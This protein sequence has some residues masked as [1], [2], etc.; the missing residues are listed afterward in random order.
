[1]PYDIIP[2]MAYPTILHRWFE[3]VWS[4]G[5][6]S[7]VDELLAPDGIIHRLDESGT[8]ARGPEQFKPF[9]RRML[10]AFPDM[11]VTV[12]DYIEQGDKIAARWSVRMT[13]HGEGLGIL[14]TGRTVN[15]TGMSFG[16]V[17]KGQLQEGWNNWDVHS[18]L[19]QIGSLPKT[20]NP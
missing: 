3:E 6:E 4:Q 14:P 13:H 7:V 1:M 12:E 5:N 19:E 18:M 9:L 20:P 2:A 8:E 16:R 11:R 17:S 10:A 15:L